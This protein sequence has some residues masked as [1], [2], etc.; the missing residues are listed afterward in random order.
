[1]KL[2]KLQ[3]ESL[4][5]K[6]T[7]LETQRNKKKKELGFWSVIQLQFHTFAADNMVMRISNLKSNENT[8]KDMGLE[9][10][11]FVSK[12]KCD[13]HIKWCETEIHECWN[14]EKFWR[15]IY[16]GNL[17]KATKYH[18]KLSEADLEENELYLE[19]IQKGGEAKLTCKNTH[20]YYEIGDPDTINI[21]TGEEAY[22]QQSIIIKTQH[23]NRADWLKLIT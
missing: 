9:E 10:N 22:R 11:E 8:W 12:Y 15:Y 14:Y 23:D 16:N 7:N 2:N 6:I 18:D 13:K 3:Q 19:N 21:Y 20:K 5:P 1:M 4:Y 17:A